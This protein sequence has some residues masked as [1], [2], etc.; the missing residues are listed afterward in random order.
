MHDAQTDACGHFAPDVGDHTIVAA[1]HSAYQYW[2]VWD[3]A[4]CGRLYRLDGA[5][6]A[7]EADAH[8][9]HEALVHVPGM[10][11][12]ALSRALVL[13][14][15]DGGSAYELLRYAALKEVVVA[16]L[17]A[18]VIDMAQRYLHP[19]EQGAF[20]H[21]RLKAVIGD[22]RNY[23]ARAIQ[24]GEQFDLIVFDLT[25]PS[26]SAP[27]HE[28]AFFERCKQLL[29]PRGALSVQLGSPRHQAAQVNQLA[30]RLAAH[31]RYVTPFYPHIPLYGGP[32][33]MA[34]ASDSLRPAMTSSHALA[35]AL[36]DI[37]PLRSISATTFPQL[38]R[39]PALA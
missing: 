22:A 15:G 1:A 18:D 2:E 9:G 21:P 34:C 16:E 33:A 8:V 37:G 17:D 10:A 4:H 30:Q 19:I 11:H 35:A 13:G 25:E 5:F 3:T 12:G 28:T 14:G 38:F 39:S 20:G 27:L 7:C 23:V 29:T 6:M 26:V 32:W 36:R 31:F 24:A